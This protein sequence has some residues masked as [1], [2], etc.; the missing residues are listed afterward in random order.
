MQEVVE[1]L[2]ANML[3]VLCVAIMI[4][5]AVGFPYFAA[6]MNTGVQ[7]RLKTKTRALRELR[8]IQKYSFVPPGAQPGMNSTSTI[9][10]PQLVTRYKEAAAILV[11]DSDAIKTLAI[12]HNKKNFLPV[13]L[14]GGIALF[15]VPDE[16]HEE[17]V[18][19]QFYEA[20]MT[21]YA[22][23]FDLIHAGSPP[24]RSTLTQDLRR[25][26]AQ[27]RDQM[28]QK[29]VDDSLSD[30][31]LLQLKE[32]LSGIRTELD[33]K[34]AQSIQI[35]GNSSALMLPVFSAAK[36]PSL[37]EM[38]NWQWT[39]WITRDVLEGVASANESSGSVASAPVKRIISLEISPLPTTPQGTSAPP[40]WSSQIQKNYAISLTGRGNNAIYQVVMVNLHLVV[41]T[42]RIPEVLD[43]IAK[44]NFMSVVD[45]DVYESN[46]AADRRLGFFYGTSAV[47]NLQLT[48]E[49]V[50]FKDWLI[51][52][53][54]AETRA[55]IGLPPLPPSPNGSNMP[56][57]PGSN[58]NRY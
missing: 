52:F 19:R 33:R 29:D 34:A 18:A 27:Y 58:P 32:Y 26:A 14:P 40:S 46:A 45:L 13:A 9:V 1:W 54:P 3:I 55:A 49:T 42:K 10:N 57:N 6:S 4:A 35:Y 41:E 20:L 22:S 51:P 23:L 43:A 53:L 21:E 56:G 47:S 15:P 36:P 2:K 7:E 48:L 16:E 44:Q 50:W 30:E 28:L 17:V 8:N 39:Y 31:E 24:D 12:D 11:S 25:S 37:G 38:F 5:A